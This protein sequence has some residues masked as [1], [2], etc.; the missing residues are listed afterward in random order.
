M[1]NEKPSPKPPLEHTFSDD[2]LFKMV[3]VKREDLLKDLVAKVLGIQPGLITGFELLNKSLDPAQIEGKSC[4]LDINLAFQG[5]L[6]NI[7]IQVAKEEDYVERVLFL[8]AQNASHALKR[9][10]RYSALPKTIVVS[11]MHFKRFSCPETHSHFRLLEERRRELLTDKMAFHFFE[12][13]KL[14]RKNSLDSPLGRWLRLFYAKTEADLAELRE[15]EDPMIAQAV[16]AYW[17]CA[18]STEF[19]ELNRQRDI[20]RLDYSSAIARAAEKGEQRGIEIGEQRGIEIGKT[21]ERRVWQSE[22]E[23]LL[24]QIA[25]LRASSNNQP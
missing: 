5:H 9:G 15:K 25:Q 16:D 8:W 21:E 4:L 7:E 12:L 2:L 24:A 13:P 3:F 22:K 18:K 20:V 6:V 17:E 1:Q 14:D 23:A 10:D 11:I 19:A